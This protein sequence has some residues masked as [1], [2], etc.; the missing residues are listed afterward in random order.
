MLMLRACFLLMVHFVCLGGSAAAQADRPVITA[1]QIWGNKAIGGAELKQLMVTQASTWY[2]FLPW[3]ESRVFY[4]DTAGRDLARL[5]T[6]YRDAGY[7]DAVVD[8]RVE[9]M[10]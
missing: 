1:V 10:G 5:R 4:S 2:D 3:V 9:Q 7:L 8:S 6:R